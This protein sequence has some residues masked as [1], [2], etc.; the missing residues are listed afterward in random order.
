MLGEIDKD[1]YCSTG[2]IRVPLPL[3]KCF[4][5]E[6]RKCRLCPACH[7]KY[8]T[9]KQFK[10]EYGKE[11]PDDGAVYYQGGYE[12]DCLGDEWFVGTL[13]DA[14]EFFKKSEGYQWLLVVCACTPFGKPP[15]DFEPTGWEPRGIEGAG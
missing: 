1:F 11:Y 3:N 5:A 7:R 9:L 4:G 2:C 10:R 15:A 13:F 8:P 12:D 14:Q 6:N